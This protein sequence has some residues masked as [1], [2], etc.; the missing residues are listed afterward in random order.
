[1]IFRNTLT[2]YG[3][4]VVWYITFDT[5]DDDRGLEGAAVGTRYE[6]GQL[7]GSHEGL[8]Y[9]GSNVGGNEGT[10]LGACEGICGLG[11]NDGFNVGKFD[12]T[13]VLGQSE[14]E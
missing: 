12:G 6:D 5:A 14:D 10:K 9:V 1:M 4:T 8:K 11:E 13:T 3:A 2:S 7:V